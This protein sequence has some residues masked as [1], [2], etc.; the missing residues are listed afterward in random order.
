MAQR[1]RVEARR[2][3][4]LKYLGRVCRCGSAERYT[5]TGGC[6]LCTLA[7]T[8]AR[9]RTPHYRV[10]HRDAQ[11][12]RNAELRGYARPPRERDCPPR[13]DR[14]ESC[15]EDSS[16]LRLDHDHTTGAFRGWCCDGCNTGLK[17]ADSP[18]LCRLR[19]VYLERALQR[20]EAA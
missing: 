6:V 12:A 15:G 9:V 8:K 10:V 5:S 2:T 4:K 3:G 17:L 18:R 13:P 1:P 19:A 14:C 7:E 20:T 16:D 11:R